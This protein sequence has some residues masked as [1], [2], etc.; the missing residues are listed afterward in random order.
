MRILFVATI[1]KHIIRFHLPY[2]KWFKD[3]GYETHVAAKG[4]ETIPYCDLKYD[5]AIERNPYSF[6][7]IKAIKELIK[8]IKLNDYKII[9]CHT[10]MGSV[11][12]RLACILAKNKD[13]SLLYT[14]HGFS[15]HKGAPLKNWLLYYPVEKIL[16]KYT[17]AIIT[18]NSE[19]FELIK[20]KKFKTGSVFKIS[21]IG[22]DPTRFSPVSKYTK[23]KLRK[24]KGYE[25]SDFILIYAAEFIH[26]KN[27]K[28]VIDSLPSIIKEIP[29]IKILFAGR[30]V[31]MEKLKMYAVRRNVSD[32]VEFLGFR[33]DIDELYA[34]S[35]VGISTSRSEGLGLNLA[36]AMFS[37][38]PVV[39]TID[40]GHKEMIN[41]GENGYLFQQN[42]CELFAQQ[43][44]ELYKSKELRVKFALNAQKT[45]QKFSLENPLN[46]MA[47]IYQLYL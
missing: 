17:D 9:H 38:L 28:F 13:T 3:K 27:H 30:G 33:S 7:N 21:G 1:D 46:E 20:R 16:A 5:L 22:V 4:N 45:I 11:I 26:R 10:A 18:I 39:A 41:S 23:L 2:L 44:T 36:E 43:I 29:T 37:G 34:L 25:E 40:K 12:S 24:E 47:S 8:I 35:D 6:K 14:A 42:N 32:F 31:L 19:D 15:F